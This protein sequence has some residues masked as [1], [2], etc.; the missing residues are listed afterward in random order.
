[1]G[2]ENPT[3]N[4]QI[5]QNKKFNERLL[6]RV[7]SVEHLPE[8]NNKLKESMFGDSELVCN[9]CINKGISKSR[10]RGNLNKTQDDIQNNPRELQVCIYIMTIII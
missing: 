2:G 8:K 6:N 1:M 9:Y 4:E 5:F 7:S 3:Q 10:E